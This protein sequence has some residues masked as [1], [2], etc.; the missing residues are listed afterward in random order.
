[1]CNKIASEKHAKLILEQFADNP[2]LPKFYKNPDRYSF[3]LELSFL[4]DRYNQLKKNLDTFD[5]FNE[6]IVADYF[7]MKSLIFS[8][9]TLQEDEYKLYRQLFDIIYSSLP[10][11]DL[12]V[13]LHKS[14]DNLLRN[15]KLRGREYEQDIS[16]D[17]LKSIENGY[18]SFFKQQNNIKILL[19]DTNTIDFVN[20]DNHYKMLVNTIFE[21]DYS[22]GI[23]RI[24][25]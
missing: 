7:F 18:F 6:L 3:P 25:F 2:F 10:K 4:A 15:I 24:V 11:P 23:N 19:I 1:L 16:Y 9:S 14:V 5:L 17:Y 12:Y 13:Y 22:D 8:S 20:N 21:K